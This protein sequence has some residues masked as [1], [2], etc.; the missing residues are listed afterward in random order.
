MRIE[1]VH[2]NFGD[3]VDLLHETGR[4]GKFHVLA[5]GSD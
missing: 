3:L 4:R 5:I 2:W 1:G